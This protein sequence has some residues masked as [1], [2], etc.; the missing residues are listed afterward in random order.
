MTEAIKTEEPSINEVLTRIHRA[1]G[2]KI[3]ERSSEAAPT[4]DTQ[5][6]YSIPLNMSPHASQQ[7]LMP[8]TIQGPPPPAEGAG[9]LISKNTQITVNTAFNALA[10]TVLRHN[11]ETLE[12]LV[13]AMLRPILQ[14]WLDA[15]LPSMV[16]RL[17]RAEIERVSNPQA[18]VRPT[19]RSAPATIE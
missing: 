16:E 5:T 7:P 15:N 2:E 6:S 8:A 13:R 1:T 14:A 12:D 4:A 3:A 11:S 19:S 18:P 17:V 9:E 10:Q